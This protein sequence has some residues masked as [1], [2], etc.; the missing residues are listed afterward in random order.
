MEDHQFQRL[1]ELFPVV[2]S[3]TYCAEDEAINNANA[4]DAAPSD[5]PAKPLTDADMPYDHRHLY[6]SFVDEMQVEKR[7]STAESTTIQTQTQMA[8][9]SREQGFWDLLKTAMQARLGDEEA[10]RFCDTFRKTHENLVTKTLSLDDIE[11][12]ATHTKFRK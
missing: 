1:L 12:I 6:T 8:I 11:R 4:D 10:Q 3:S 9:V 5:R 7:N 2:R